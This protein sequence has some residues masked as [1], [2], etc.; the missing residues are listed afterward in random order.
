MFGMFFR[1]INSMRL[2]SVDLLVQNM[3]KTVLNADIFRHKKSVPE[4]KNSAKC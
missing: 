1:S 3:K 4:T 2:L